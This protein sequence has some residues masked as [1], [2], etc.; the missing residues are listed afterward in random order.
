[1]TA[2]R[3]FREW[4]G[5]RPFVVDGILAAFLLVTALLSLTSNDTDDRDADTFATVLAVLFS[6][7][8]SWRR[9]RPF[10]VLLLVGVSAVV[11]EV[12]EYN[13]SSNAISVLLCLYAVAAHAPRREA[14]LGGWLMAGALLIAMAANWEDASSIAGIIGN[15][16]LFAA[17]WVGGDNVRQ[18]RERL[19]ALQQRAVMAELARDEEAARAVTAERTRIA[20]ELHDVVAHS[21]SVMVVQ[22]GAARRLLQRDD[23]DPAR[24][25]EALESVETTGRES[26]NELRRLLGVLR[27]EDDRSFGR[28]PQPSVD[29][30]D[31]IVAQARDAGLVVDLVV[32]GEPRPLSPG[33]DLTA[34]RIV[35]EALTN[36]M[37]H[38][39]PGA[40]ADVHLSYGAGALEV[41]V[42]DDGR[43]RDEAL[44]SGGHGLVGM[45]ERVSLFGG[46]LRAGNRPGGGFE[47]HAELPLEVP[48]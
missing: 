40:R 48:A 18:R 29:H 1:V 20:R 11:Y 25:V 28:V 33:V 13:D 3:R 23:P 36:V 27:K 47:I 32:H 8:V 26:L 43:G 35:Q 10:A 4:L 30:L 19:T 22:A 15:C 2:M 7:P 14:V 37:K 21:V 16:A 5:A 12:L 38:G 39:G 24:A 44:P 45:Q 31:T 34:Y 42:R 46:R 17:A 41:H 9:R 6:A